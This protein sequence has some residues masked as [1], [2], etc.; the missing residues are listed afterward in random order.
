MRQQVEEDI[1]TC[2]DKGELHSATLDVFRK[3]P[4]PTTSPLWSHPKVTLT[5][6][7][8]ADSDPETICRYVH[9]QIM[10]FERG[11]AMQNL[12]DRTRGY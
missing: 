6:H 11:E 7:T 5:P 10:R 3:E 9:Q 4:L 12:V 8:A 2:L 1:I